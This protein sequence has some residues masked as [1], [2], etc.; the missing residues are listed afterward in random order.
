[1]SD[2]DYITAVMDRLPSISA[3]DAEITKKYV[4]AHLYN[5]GFTISEAV[6]YCECMEEFNPTLDESVAL[7]R[8]YDIRLQVKERKKQGVIQCPFMLVRGFVGSFVAI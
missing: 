1:M 5:S 3:D 8:M 6:A 7:K 2:L 4:I